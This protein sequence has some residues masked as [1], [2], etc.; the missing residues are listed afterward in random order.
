MAPTTISLPK[1][2]NT[3]ISGLVNLAL[4]S[5]KLNWM[6]RP[7]K[8][9]D[10]I[11]FHTMDGGW[12]G[13]GYTLSSYP[14]IYAFRINPNDSNSGK[15]NS[16]TDNTSASTGQITCQSTMSDRIVFFNGYPSSRTEQWTGDFYWI[17][18]ARTYLTD[19]EVQQVISYNENL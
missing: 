2:V 1:M 10:T 5:T 13:G 16:Y 8:S 7:A 18:V 19:A 14:N 9:D 4:S 6:Y 11:M 15:Y 3:L 17:Y 12:D